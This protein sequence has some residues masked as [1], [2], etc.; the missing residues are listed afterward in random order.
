MT[1][2]QSGFFSASAGTILIGMRDVF[3]CDF[4]LALAS[5]ADAS[6]A[7][8]LTESLDIADFQREGAARSA[9]C[10][11]GQG[12]KCSANRAPN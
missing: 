9:G 12:V 1:R 6:E 5:Y 2:I 8:G 11:W 10:R 4:Y 7:T 3:A